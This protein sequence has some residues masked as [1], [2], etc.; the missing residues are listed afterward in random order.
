MS[1][2]I[3]LLP[4]YASWRGA[5]LKRTLT[6]LPLPKSEGKR[7]LRRP[8]YNWESNIRI[9]LREIGWSMGWIHY[10]SGWGPVVGSCK[11]GNEPSAFV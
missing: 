2:V 11:H 3:V 9:Y 7:P 4:Q 6:T 10:G 1:G 5:Q 8:R